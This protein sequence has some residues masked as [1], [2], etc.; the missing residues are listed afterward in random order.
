MNELIIFN[1]KITHIKWETTL[2]LL[3]N[4]VILAIVY[5]SFK[6]SQK[7]GIFSRYESYMNR[8]EHI[9]SIFM[10]PDDK[11]FLNLFLYVFT[12]QVFIQIGILVIPMYRT[13][14]IITRDNPRFVYFLPTFWSSFIY[15]DL[16]SYVWLVFKSGL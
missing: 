10:N 9:S 5:G 15:C 6:R 4:S 16:W 13:R 11:D 12:S 3:Q 8:T 7:M 2:F 1:P 14:A